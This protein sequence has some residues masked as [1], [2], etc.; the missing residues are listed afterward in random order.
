MVWSH[1]LKCICSG[2]YTFFIIDIC[3]CNYEVLINVVWTDGQMVFESLKEDGNS[4]WPHLQ[5]QRNESKNKLSNSH[6]EQAIVR[7]ASKRRLLSMLQFFQS[8]SLELFLHT[9][10]I[11][12]A[13]KQTINR[14]NLTIDFMKTPVSFTP[15]KHH[16]LLR[17]LHF[18]WRSPSWVAK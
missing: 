13:H 5:R 12:H 18:H 1:T 8:S 3:V 10:T 16:T 14:S 15:F 7:S 11:T 4:L 17:L 2:K 9:H 6:W